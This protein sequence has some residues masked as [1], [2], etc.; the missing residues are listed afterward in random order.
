MVWSDVTWPYGSTGGKTESEGTRQPRGFKWAGSIQDTRRD[1]STQSDHGGDEKCVRDVHYLSARN[2]L[3]VF[4]YA[5][6]PSSL[7]VIY[8]RTGL[9]GRTALN[10]LGLHS[11]TRDKPLRVL[12]TLG[13]FYNHGIV[14]YIR[15]EQT[16]LMPIK[17][18]LKVILC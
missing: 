3:Q 12:G 11:R 5:S 15:S 17:V 2:N 14:S 18:V 8:M 4:R 6:K 16:V 7:N 9:V 1:S 13:T 10:G